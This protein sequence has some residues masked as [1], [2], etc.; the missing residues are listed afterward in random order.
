MAAAVAVIPDEEIAQTAGKHK[1]R[2][3]D[4]TNRTC[5]GVS[6]CIIGS[7]NSTV[8][9]ESKINH[10]GNKQLGRTGVKLV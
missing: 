7:K 5:S 6:W 10:E 1:G 2:R 3:P 4:Q 8:E 9:D